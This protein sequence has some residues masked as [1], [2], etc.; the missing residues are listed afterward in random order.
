[1][2]LDV[3]LPGR[4]KI[5]LLHVTRAM[6]GFLHCGGKGGETSYKF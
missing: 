6:S 3:I 2:N 4:K 5:L 1:M